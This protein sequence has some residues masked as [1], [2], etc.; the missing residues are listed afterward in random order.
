VLLP[1]GRV[2]VGGGRGSGDYTS[3][4][5]SPPYLFKGTRPESTTLPAATGWNAPIDIGTPTP[6]AI[7]RVTL[8]G[9]GAMTHAFDQNA[10]FLELQF[11]QTATGVR[12]LAPADPNLAPPGYYLVFLLDGNGVPSVGRIIRLR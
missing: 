5:F 4:T 1:D 7:A 10:R 3:Q 11:T 6:T 12:A 2:L 8:L 9:L